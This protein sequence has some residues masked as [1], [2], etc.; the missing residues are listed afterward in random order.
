MAT[1][2]ERCKA[3]GLSSAA[4]LTRITGTSKETLTNWLKDKPAL[5]DTVLRGAIGSFQMYEKLK[6]D[7]DLLQQKY[8]HLQNLPL[9]S[10]PEQQWIFT[11]EQLQEQARLIEK[12]TSDN[13]RLSA[14]LQFKI[15]E[16][17]CLK[18]E[19]EICDSSNAK[20]FTR[21]NEL[22]EKLHYLD[23]CQFTLSDGSFCKEHS[24]FTSKIGT[25]NGY[26]IRLC[27]AHSKKLSRLISLQGLQDNQLADMLSTLQS[28]GA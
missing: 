20:L 2:A 15:K 14:E 1:L 26:T 28:E 25:K 23:T 19:Y 8:T 7:Y 16:L 6:T 11:P 4:E 9:V 24:D 13:V 17:D 3:A 12:L 5:F 21:N 10:V 18:K 27:K 22:Q